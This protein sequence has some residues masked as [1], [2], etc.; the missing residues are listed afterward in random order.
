LIGNALNHRVIKTSV[1]KLS[2]E[3]SAPSDLGG[4]NEYKRDVAEGLL[5]DQLQQIAEGAEGS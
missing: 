2:K 4:S 5:E 1:S 3:F